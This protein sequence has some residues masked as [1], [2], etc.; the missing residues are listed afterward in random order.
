MEEELRNNFDEL[1]ARE[2]ALAKSEQKFRSLFTTMV[3]GSAMSEIVYDGAGAPF[4]YRI[5][6]VNPAF[7]KIFGI[8]AKDAVGKLSREAF[9]IDEPGA[10]AIYARVADSGK[11]ETFEIWYPPMRKHFAISVYSPGKGTF[12]TVFED[13]TDRIK[14]EEELRASYEQVSAMEEELRNNFDELA[15]REQALAKS[16]QKFRS[17]FTTMVEG[18]AMS[19]IVYDSTGTP[20]EYRIIEVNPAFEK[21]FGISAKDA[22]GQLSH[23]AFGVDEPGALAVYA[24]VTESGKP[25]TFEIWYPPMR[26]HFAISVYSPGKGTFA[27][28][29]EDITDRIKKE[30]E[31]RASY[32]QVSAMEEEL[33]TNFEELAAREQALRISEEQY[34]RIVETASE[35]IWAMDSGL[36]TTF[37]NPRLADMLGYRPDEMM[38]HSID[39]YIV[40]DELPLNE[41]QISQRRAGASG[42]YERRFRSRTGGEVWCIVSATPVIGPGGV[43]TGSFAMLTDIT[44]R[45]EIEQDLNTRYGELNV[46][47]EEMSVALEELRSTEES[48]VARNH[49]LESQKL[50]LAESGEALRMA[51]R[52]LSLLSSVTRHD[53]LNQLDDSQWVRGII[54]AQ[55]DGWPAPESYRKRTPCDRANPSPDLVYQGVRGDRCSC[56]GLAECQTRG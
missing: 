34:R 46:A 44:R 17:L 5:I 11:P 31:L 54:R 45:K 28:V 43:F 39:E 10:L 6:E 27:T 12:A 52:K 1:A 29:F 33:R 37:V 53:V 8:S 23:E 22:V 55:R 13:I 9:G 16:E 36:R 35:G 4:E 38:G 48:L 19:E 32:E 47:H 40:E 18:C 3:E 20:V 41:E 26:K 7:E 51:N 49:E 42:R 14:K 2:Q 56:P 24:R 30:E 25:E 50:A 15:A 21:I